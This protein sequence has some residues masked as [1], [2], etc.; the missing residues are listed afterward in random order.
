M[1]YIR[2]AIIILFILCLYSA[3]NVEGKGN[4]K[5][6]DV[7]YFYINVCPSC[8]EARDRID[9]LYEE[10]R[11]R[12]INLNIRSYNIYVKGIATFLKDFYQVY[13][14]P[15]KMQEV[16]IMFVGSAYY[17]GEKAI[18]EGLR[19]ALGQVEQ[20]AEISSA[21]ERVRSNQRSTKQVPKDSELVTMSSLKVMAVG[22]INGL[23]PCSLSMLLFLLSLVLV[24]R[25]KAIS[26][27]SGF[28]LGKFFTYLILGTLLYQYLGKVDMKIYGPVV[29]GAF[30]IFILLVAGANI[31]D[32]WV[33]KQQRYEKIRNQLPTKIRG[34]CHGSIKKM[35][36]S[37][38]A[39]SLL[40][41]FILGCLISVTEFLCTGQLFIVSIIYGIQN[42]GMMQGKAFYYLI[43][44][45][46]F[47]MMPLIIVMIAVLK[48][49]KLMKMTDLLRERL[50]LIK[51]LTAIALLVMGVAMLWL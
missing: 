23:N 16:P 50:P 4:E 9:K 3:F 27:G 40:I 2:Q 37:S 44:Y 26:L 36:S 49:Q 17:Q 6:L 19:Q 29:K 15:S 5:E 30:F 41:G 20:G 24:Q 12:N 14:V 22:F 47:F 35:S 1:K 8:Q 11:E 42:K 18:E 7:T 13:E 25:K 45:T 21:Y 32:F 48:T 33:S 10:A 34:W 43:T 51:L 39:F 38:V 46:L 28:I 31:Y